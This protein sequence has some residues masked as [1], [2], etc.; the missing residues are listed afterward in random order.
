MLEI[1]ELINKSKNIPNELKNIVSSICKAYIKES[2]G[3][4]TLE[5]INNVCNAYYERIDE[6]IDEF[7]G[8]NN[9]FARTT[10]D[11]DENCN[12]IHKVS[13]INEK[14][15]IKLIS[16]LTHELGH[17]MTEPKPCEI[18]DNG[19]YPLIKKTTTIFFDCRY[20]LDDIFLTQDYLGFRLADGFLESICSKIFNSNEFRQDLLNKGYDLKDYVYKDERLFVSRIYDD[21]KACFELFDY[22]M[23]GKLFEFSCMTFNSN[24]EF[25]KFVNENKLK[26]IFSIIDEANEALWKLK[27]YEGQDYTDYVG[28]VIQDY[29]EKKDM[30]ILLA[31]ACIEYFGKSKDEN[32]DKLVNIYKSTI[33]KQKLLPIPKKIRKKYLKKEF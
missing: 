24:E 15:Y 23:N 27:P 10:T 9:S 17:V 1:D 14:N 28:N 30:V 29:L 13:Y 19:H 6:N 3:L 20:E 12:V 11:Y 32:F 22:V 25:I 5:G 16:I 4:I 33:N 26:T 31:N 7:R 8:E 18:L 21:Y 2:N